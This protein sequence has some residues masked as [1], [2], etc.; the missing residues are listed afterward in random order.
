MNL[1]PDEIIRRSQQRYPKITHRKS[2][3]TPGEQ[4]SEASSSTE[5]SEGSTSSLLSSINSNTERQPPSLVQQTTPI[6]RTINNSR[7]RIA[8][9]VSQSQQ[10]TALVRQ[11]PQNKPQT[12]QILIMDGLIVLIILFL[13]FILLKKYFQVELSSFI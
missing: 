6:I 3:K 4:N 8:S 5:T 10:S 9:P 1:S 11:T 13:L 12:T 7:S 2:P